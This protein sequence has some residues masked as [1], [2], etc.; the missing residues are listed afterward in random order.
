LF[1]FF[2]PVSLVNLHTCFLP[3]QRSA[4]SFFILFSRN[5]NKSKASVCI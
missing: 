4:F 3:T 2:P 5:I 1:L